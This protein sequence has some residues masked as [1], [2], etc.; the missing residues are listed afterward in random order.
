MRQK[1]PRS[2]NRFVDHH[3]CAF[4][5]NPSQN[6]VAR[7]SPSHLDEV[8]AVQG[9]EAQKENIGD[10]EQEMQIEVVPSS[11]APSVKRYPSDTYCFVGLCRQESD[12]WVYPLVFGLWVFCL[13]VLL[14]TLLILNTAFGRFSSTRP[15]DGDHPFL[16]AD[17]DPIVRASQILAILVQ[18]KEC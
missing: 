15:E 13:Q 4:R 8:E 18:R 5:M 16:P 14:L 1:D 9:D 12:N 3:H 11:I 2:H 17:V 6:K 7:A 10:L